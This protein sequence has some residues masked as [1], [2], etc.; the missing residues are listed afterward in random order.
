MEKTLNVDGKRLLQTVQYLLLDLQGAYELLDTNLHEKGSQSS[1]EEALKLVK[2][3]DPEWEDPA[4]Y[5]L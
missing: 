3:F 4:A 2:E 1:A 5:A